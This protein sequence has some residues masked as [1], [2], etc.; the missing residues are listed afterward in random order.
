[1]G[2]VIMGG[3]LCVV[4]SLPAIAIAVI[5]NATASRFERHH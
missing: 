4:L 3:A 5:V 1:M 2:L